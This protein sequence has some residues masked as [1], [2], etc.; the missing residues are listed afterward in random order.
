MKILR[1]EPRV[2]L[3]NQVNLLSALR[4]ALLI[5]PEEFTEFD[6]YTTIAGLSYLGTFSHYFTNGAGDFRT[7]LPAENP[8]KVQNIVSKQVVYFR[9]LYSPLLDTLPN[10]TIAQDHV[11]PQSTILRQDFS[12][13]KRANMVARLPSEF[14]ATLYRHYQQ[15]FH[16]RLGE[17]ERGSAFGGEFEMKVAADPELPVEVKRSIRETVGWSS[18]VQTIKGVFTAGIG[19]SIKYVFAKMGKWWSGKKSSNES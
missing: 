2:R 9:R 19:R 6:L 16:I 14:K 17:V 5:L 13:T 7:F 8:K 1:D 15:K 10:V 3:A 18:F 4:A 11:D 12:P